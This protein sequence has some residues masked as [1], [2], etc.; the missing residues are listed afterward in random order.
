MKQSQLNEL[1]KDVHNSDSKKI[2]PFSNGSESM[3]W[4]FSNCEKCKKCFNFDE[5]GF[6][7]LADIRNGREC[8]LK[9]ALDYGV[10][11]GEIPLSIAEMIGYKENIFPERCK[12]FSTENGNEIINDAQLSLFL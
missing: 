1:I 2:T 7:T 8:V 5:D 10:F 11:A 6:P 12:Q 4:T 9:Y 3:I